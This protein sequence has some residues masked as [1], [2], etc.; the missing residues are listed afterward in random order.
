M[1]I[2]SK[3]KDYSIYF[4]NSISFILK[5]KKIDNSF[6]VV[7]R[8]VYNNYSKYFKGIKNIS[9]V[10]AVEKNKNIN[11]ALKICE[12]IIKL[13]SKRNTTL[14]SFGGGI[15]QDLTGFVSNVVYRGIKWIYVPTTLLSMCDSC[16]GGKTSLNYRNYKNLLGTFFPPNEIY[17]CSKFIKSLKIDDYYSGLGEVF[18]FNIMQGYDHFSIISDNI[19]ALVDRNDKL[20]EKSIIQSLDYKKRIVEKDEFD[21]GERIKLNFGH[22][23]GHAIETITNYRIPHGT[24]VAIGCIMA[25]YISYSRGLISNN[26]K[27]KCEIN[28]LKIINIDK[29]K[30][31]WDIEQFITI[32]HSD[33]KQTSKSITIILKKGANGD[34]VIVNDVKKQEIKKAIEYFIKIYGANNENYSS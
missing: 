16:V 11:T 22:T 15:I 34:L 19:N 21:R 4:V 5:L 28:L 20:I 23:F 27:N 29:K 10:D 13:D 31:N 7:D 30:L 17:V 32:M 2:K 33:K 6:F 3:Q 1:I 24:S 18:K 26:Y 25:N 9:I 14:I 8:N 12:Q